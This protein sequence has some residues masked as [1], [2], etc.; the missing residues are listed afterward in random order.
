M[1][2]RWRMIRPLAGIVAVPALAQVSIGP[3]GIR[4][5]DTV[6]DAGGIHTATADVGPHGIQGH[7]GSSGGTTISANGQTRSVDCGGGTLT[8]DGNGN[9]LTVSNCATVA[10]NGNG[11]EVAAA[12]AQSGRLSTMGNRNTVR[13]H[14]APSIHVAIANPGTKNVVYRR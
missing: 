1:A 3:H 7:R 2:R 8:V 13:W 14:A 10:V 4:S 12:F 6:I 11:N 9:H 5:G